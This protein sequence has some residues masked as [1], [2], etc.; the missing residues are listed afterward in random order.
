[1]TVENETLIEEQYLFQIPTAVTKMEPV[2][3][4]SINYSHNHQIEELSLNVTLN[5]KL[6]TRSIQKQVTNFKFDKEG[7]CRFYQDEIENYFIE[8]EIKLFNQK[9]TNPLTNSSC[10][11]SITY[12]KKDDALH[13]I[14]GKYDLNELI[15][16]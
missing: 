11:V 8:G 9:H 7:I 12:G 13:F 14:K 10:F 15:K 5:P 4:F 6:A 1:M 2:F 16:T 3:L